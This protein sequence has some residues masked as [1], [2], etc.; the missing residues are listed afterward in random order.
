[1]LQQTELYCQHPGTINLV[2]LTDTHLSANEDDSLA[3]VNTTETL[4]HVI[5]ALQRNENPDLVVITGDLA[6][7]PDQQ[8]YKKLAL[9]SQGIDAPVFCLAGNHDDPA[10]MQEL[11]NTGNVSTANFLSVG[12]WSIV[13]LN[14]HEAG[15][16][17]GYLSAAELSALDTA[18][19]RSRDRYVL[20]CLH[21]PPVN[22]QSL[23]MDS[24][25]LK[26]NN[27]MFQIVDRYRNVKGIIWGHIHQEFSRRRNGALL[28]G[29]P[30]TCV[31]FLPR[32]ERAAIDDKPP[33]YRTLT[34]TDDGIIQTHIHWL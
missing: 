9:L 6:E 4:C 27:A 14:S 29:S 16:H 20:I 19:Q 23:W 8:T 30:S 11:L 22:I 10:M 2:Q 13:L 17:A 15:E 34:L 21:H 24:M 33:A 26:N 7:T 1:M 32:S 3:G 12:R 25:G 5:A 18:L 31:Q 28:L